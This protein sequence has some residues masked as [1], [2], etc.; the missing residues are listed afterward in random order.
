M[1]LIASKASD[2]GVC[3]LLEQEPPFYTA[4]ETAA[5][6]LSWMLILDVIA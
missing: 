2:D 4:S 6:V 1:R 5:H 3:T